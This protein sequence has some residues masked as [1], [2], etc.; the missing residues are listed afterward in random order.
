MERIVS[1]P[2]VLLGKPT[3]RGTRL[4]VEFILARLADGW[5]EQ[6]LLDNYPRLTPEDLR[7][8]FSYATESLKDGLFVNVPTLSE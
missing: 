4:S 1:D 8:V 5:T 7:A 3:I 6:Q 2:E